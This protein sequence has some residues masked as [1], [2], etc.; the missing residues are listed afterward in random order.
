[1]ATRKKAPAFFTPR[2]TLLFPKLNAPDYGNDQFPKP[3]GEYSTNAILKADDPIT[4]K[5][6]GQLQPFYDEAMAWADEQFKNLKVETRKKLK[7]VTQN[8]LFG[9]VYDK[10]TEEPTGEIRFKFAMKAG[11]LR[12]KDNKPWSAKPDL[13]DAKGRPMLKAPDIWSGTVAKVNFEIGL[14]KDG[15]P[16]YF[17]PG[18]GAAGLSLKLR[19]VQI[20]ELVSGG[21]RTASSYGFGEEDG[22]AHEDQDEASGGF[23]DETSG[24]TEDDDEIP[25]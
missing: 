13:F 6:I 5:F 18:T 17:V 20:I 4:K 1:M 24:S 3:D 10:E 12:K 23:G 16:G 8:P 25:F 7:S 21:Q 19:A 22:Y 14:N 9:T 11:G 15:V 2:V